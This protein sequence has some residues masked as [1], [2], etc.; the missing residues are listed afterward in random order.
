M[1]DYEFKERKRWVFFGIPWTFTVYKISEDRITIDKGF[2]NKTEDDCYMYKVNDVKLECSFFERI[3]RLGTI[4]CFTGDTT[5]RELCIK[6]V[7]NAKVIKDYIFS[8]SETEKLKH[9]TI[10]T[11]DIGGGEAVMNMDIDH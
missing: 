6:H 2:L 5:D 7:K 3:F 10:N 11:M 1:A 9:R 4:H 8:K